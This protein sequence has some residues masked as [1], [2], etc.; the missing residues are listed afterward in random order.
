[1]LRS[2]RTLP[3]AH[4]SRPMPPRHLPYRS[5]FPL[6]RRWVWPAGCA[7]LV[8]ACAVRAQPAPPAA[9]QDHLSVLQQLVTQEVDSVSKY[10]QNTLDAPARVTVV[11]R[12]EIEA[13]GHETLADVLKVVPGLYVTHD[14]GYSAL[15][16]RGFN[17]PGDFNARTL[18]LIDGYRLNDVVFD[19]ALPEYEFPVVAE[20]IKRL[21]YIAGPSSSVY[22][23]NA[24]FGIANVV[25]LDGAD[26]PGAHVKL[27]AGSRGTRRAVGHYGAVLSGGQDLFLGAAL[28]ASDGDTLHLE[29]FATPD[30]PGGRVAGLD[31]SR[32]GAL[33]AKL[34]DGAWQFKLSASERRKDLATAPFDTAFGRAGTYYVDAN[35][36]AEAAWSPGAGGSDWSPQA[37]L[38]LGHYRFEGRYVYEDPELRNVDDVRATWLSGELRGTWRGWL[39]HTVVVGI[40]GR[41]ALEA[42]M[43][44]FD[45]EP[46]ESYLDHRSR[47]HTVGLFVQDQYR[48]SERW[49]LTTGMRLD[50][51]H[52]FSPELSPRAAL[53]YR[54]DEHRSFKL[55]VGRAFRTPNL[56]ERYYE[57]GGFSQI[58]NPQLDRERIHTIELAMEQALDQRTRLAASLYRYELQDLIELQPVEGED[59]E[60]YRNVGSAR[61][62][63]LE[64]EL[65]H[66]RPGSVELR[67]SAAFQEARSGG[68]RLSNAPRWLLKAGAGLPVAGGWL[69][70]VELNAMG[71]R[72]T[73][74]GERIDA[75]VLADALLRYRTSSHG[76]WQLRATNLGDVR[77]DDPATP[78]LAF[79]RVP[80]PGRRLQLSWQGRF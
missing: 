44:N 6:L 54:P 26:A 78:G 60:Q 23:G 15:G 21:E 14:R 28:Y 63:G 53:V 4:R 5:R 41:K 48:L 8:A 68:E 50:F 29:H 11:R 7:L 51:V 79:E 2:L 52:D 72:R 59:Y 64:L 16:V 27:G 62:V 45:V 46:A 56:S 25:T 22:G 12:R 36:F 32:Y 76:E 1:M 61:A 13:H 31:G 39:N 57:D 75:H 58:A 18:A 10:S 19:Q 55:L 66:A 77:Y 20:W 47:P 9:A 43:R 49:S 67:A 33:L 42:T 35:A 3:G 70:G 80:Q 34:R 17:R 73:R 71:A 40:D 74:G 69:L 37:R 38:A 30:N 24:L 65:E